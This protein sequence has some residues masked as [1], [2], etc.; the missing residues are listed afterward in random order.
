ML[1]DFFRGIVLTFW[2]I[3]FL[4]ERILIPL[5]ESVWKTETRNYYNPLISEP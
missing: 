5:F 3:Y 4:V 2:K 1:L